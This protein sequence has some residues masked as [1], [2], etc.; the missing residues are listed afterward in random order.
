MIV[1]PSFTRNCVNLFIRIIREHSR[2][3]FRLY[4]DDDLISF[5]VTDVLDSIQFT[6]I[7]LKDLVEG[8]ME[9]LE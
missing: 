6:V 9:S 8:E 7:K 2:R 3:N 1:S 4:N 5:W